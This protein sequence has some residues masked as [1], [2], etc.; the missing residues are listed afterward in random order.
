M[1][2]WTQRYTDLLRKV[3]RILGFVRRLENLKTI[4]LVAYTPMMMMMQDSLNMSTRM[5]LAR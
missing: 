4:G 5:S 2:G 3:L 1:L